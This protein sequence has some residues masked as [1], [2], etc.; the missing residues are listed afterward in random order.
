[1]WQL[2]G[3]EVQSGPGAL[4]CSRP[5]RPSRRSS[6]QRRTPPTTASPGDEPGS[7]CAP[8][9]SLALLRDTGAS[10]WPTSGL[11]AVRCVC[12]HSGH[13]VRCRGSWREAHRCKRGASRAV[14]P[15]SA[16]VGLRQL[17]PRREDR[18]GVP[19]LAPCA[20][21]R[22]A[23][24]VQPRSRLYGP[25]SGSVDP[26]HGRS[27]SLRLPRDRGPL[28]YLAGL[29]PLPEH[30]LERLA[31]RPGAHGV[32]TTSP[33]AST[34]SPSTIRSAGVRTK[35]PS[36]APNWIPDPMHTKRPSRRSPMSQP[37]TCLNWS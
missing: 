2:S 34:H 1:M 8:S 4:R 26:A 32:P 25:H 29:L 10:R 13:P 11:L 27:R 16:V 9:P 5:A 35:S 18:H 31:R 3:S 24:G 30:H 20:P 12:S 19:W 14:W 37:S 36:S 15:R 6:G 7:A 22:V 17:T 28:A 33:C 23:P 21:L